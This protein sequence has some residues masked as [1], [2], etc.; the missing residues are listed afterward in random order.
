MPYRDTEA[1]YGKL[2]TEYQVEFAGGTCTYGHF[3]SVQL[4]NHYLMS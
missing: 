1:E 3:D 2:G 4:S